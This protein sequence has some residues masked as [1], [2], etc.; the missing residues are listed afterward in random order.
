MR[1]VGLAKNH[2]LLLVR[3]NGK[4]LNTRDITF[5]QNISCFFYMHTTFSLVLFSTLSQA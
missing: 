3:G 1:E 2:L 5:S 4:A